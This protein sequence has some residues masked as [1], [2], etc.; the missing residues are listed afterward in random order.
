MA[1]QTAERWRISV[2]S[3]IVAVGVIA[4]VGAAT[5]L[6]ISSRRVLGWVIVAAALAALVF[7]L[8]ERLDRIVPRG[9]AVL[10][11]AL[12][13]IGGAGVV[14][15]GVVDSLSRETARLQRAAPQRAAA[16]ENSEQFGELAKRLRL[17]ERTQAIVD[18]VPQRLQGGDTSDVLRTNA[19]RGVAYLATAVLTIFFI[20]HGNRLIDG[21]IRQVPDE[22]M[23]QRVRRAVS[24]TYH[25]GFGYAR[26]AIGLAIVA[27]VVTTLLA[28]LADLPGAVPLGLWVAL[29]SFIPVIGSL[30]GSLPLVVLAAAASPSRAMALALAFVVYQL[31]ENLVVHPRLER[32]T[33]RPGPLFM[34]VAGFIGLELSGIGGAAVA[35]LAVCLIG[36][37]ARNW[38]DNPADPLTATPI[39]PQAPGLATEGA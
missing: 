18:A 31:I 1:S 32:R 36:A 3:L 38:L 30:V 28:T 6:V 13:G 5:S 24:A 19:T 22:V 27:G 8:I 26:G 15:Y 35:L 16:L 21:A 10:V 20:L 7:P 39:T 23:R 37:A 33:M 14:T 29:W 9:V 4:A 2:R 11:V 12:L 17:T 25:C 34:A